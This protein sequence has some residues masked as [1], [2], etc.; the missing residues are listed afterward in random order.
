[1]SR[2]S[3]NSVVESGW[4]ERAGERSEPERERQLDSTAPNGNQPAA[5]PDPQVVAQAAKAKRRRFRASD[6]QRILE[7]VDQA[8][9]PGAV[10]RILRREGIYH[11]QLSKWRQQR[12]AG[13]STGLADKMPGAKGPSAKS[14]QQE[15]R[16]L[17]R[18][19]AR[20]HKQL[21]RA[22]IIIEFQKKAAA[23][24]ETTKETEES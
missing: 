2:S 24:F 17:Q 5:I 22:E 11:S 3:V 4:R 6:K 23:L 1:M 20:L 8:T 9:E 16:K 13:I 21:S 18:E 15:N 19:N 10:G 14:L 12:A 7:A